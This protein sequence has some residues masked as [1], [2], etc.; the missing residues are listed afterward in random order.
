M[1][2]LLS[3]TVLFA[4]SLAT[5][6]QPAVDVSRSTRQGVDGSLTARGATQFNGSQLDSVRRGNGI[7]DGQGN[8][9]ARRGGAFT[10]AD[11][12][13]GQRS[14]QYRR[15]D[16]GSVDAS[17]IGSVSGDKGSAE[18]SRSF[19]RG[20]DGEAS[21]QRSTTATRAE[22]GVT[23]EGSTTYTKGSGFSRSASCVDASGATVTCGSAR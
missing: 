15:S 18:G 8:A 11:G 21:G 3:F 23:Y 20:A 5:Q 22:T 13:Q 2:R 6:A 14:T 17:R 1:Q 4:A 10:T 9:A 19:E 12:T 16:D 7:S